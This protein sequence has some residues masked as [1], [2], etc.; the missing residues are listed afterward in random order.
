M[1]FQVTQEVKFTAYVHLKIFS[2]LLMLCQWLLKVFTLPDI[3][4]GSNVSGIMYSEFMILLILIIIFAV[5]ECV[6]KTGNMLI[7]QRGMKVI[8]TL[9]VGKTKAIFRDVS[10]L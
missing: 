10:G 4:T 3:K 5:V 7:L 9:C 8:V 2:F 6:L 1:F